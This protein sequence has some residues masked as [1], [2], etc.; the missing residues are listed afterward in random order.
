VIDR[1]RTGAFYDPQQTA[2][3]LVAMAA[4]EAGIRSFEMAQV[5]AL[6]C[7]TNLG[8]SRIVNVPAAAAG[9]QVRPPAVAGRFYPADAAELAKLVDDCLPKKKVAVKAWSAIMVPH[10][11]LIYS[12][13]IAAQ[14]L[15]RVKFPSTII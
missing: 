10:A 6:E 14:T 1:N 9:A 11:G 8:R 5:L 7:I 4:R 13:S 3:T 2:E 15:A 12:G